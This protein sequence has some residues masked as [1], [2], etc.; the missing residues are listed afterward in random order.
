MDNRD[1]LQKLKSIRLC[2]SAHPDNEENSEFADRIEDLNEIISFFSELKGAWLNIENNTRDYEK[3]VKRNPNTL[4]RFD[5][6]QIVKFKD[7]WPYAIA[8]HFLLSDR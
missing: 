8:T 2:L 6:G 4:I 5:S 3:E 1:F 7:E